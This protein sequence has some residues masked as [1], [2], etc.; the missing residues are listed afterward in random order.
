MWRGTD[1][2]E[3]GTSIQQLWIQ[4]QQVRRMLSLDTI[5]GTKNE[6]GMMTKNPDSTQVDM[7]LDVINL[8]FTE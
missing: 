7:Y 2:P 6:A 4:E 1:F 8:G 5:P 3:Y